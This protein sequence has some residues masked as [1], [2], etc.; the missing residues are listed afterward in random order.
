M[1]YTVSTCIAMGMW[2]GIT[3]TK[4]YG[5]HQNILQ[6]TSCIKKLLCHRTEVSPCLA[7]TFTTK[8][9]KASSLKPVVHFYCLESNVIERNREAM[10]KKLTGSMLYCFKTTCCATRES[11]EALT[12]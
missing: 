8:I 7:V 11:E 4:I 12:T 3:V 9:I 2:V 6:M 10:L 5:I 1:S